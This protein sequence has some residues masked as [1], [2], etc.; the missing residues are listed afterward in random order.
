MDKSALESVVGDLRGILEDNKKLPYGKKAKFGQN[1]LLKPEE[2]Q[3]LRA[4]TTQA[5][6]ENYER[7]EMQRKIERLEKRNQELESKS[8][9]RKLKE[10]NQ[11]LKA[12]NQK[13]SNQVMQLICERESIISLLTDYPV[14]QQNKNS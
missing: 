3:A 11:E 12:K 1:I 4:A 8:S 13:L 6:W 2:Y 5:K 9:E 7:R 14:F 10:E